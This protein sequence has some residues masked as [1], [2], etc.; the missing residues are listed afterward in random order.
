MVYLYKHIECRIINV[1][2]ILLLL[3]IFVFATVDTHIFVYPSLS[4]SLISELLILLLTTLALLCCIIKKKSFIH[5]KVDW[6]ILAWIA[7]IIIHYA[8][9][10]P[11]EQYRTIYLVVSLLLIPTVTVLLRCHL[12]SRTQCENT[13]LYTAVIHV[14]FV[15]AQWIGLIE[16]GNIYFVLTGSNENPTVTALYLVGCVP[17]IVVRLYSGGNKKIYYSFLFICIVTIA[18]LRCRT[19]YIGLSVELLIG[20]VVYF[21]N[22]NICIP[23]SY[24]LPFVLVMALTITMAGIKLY[25]MKRDSADGRILIWNI[26]AKMIMEK[27]QG[28]G[29]GLFEKHYN[30]RQAAYFAKGNGTKKEKQLADHVAMP[31]NDFLEHGVEGGVVGMVFLVVFYAIV[32]FN[33][34]REHDV[35]C[36]S[37]L[38]AFA[39]MSWTNF[40]YS[41]IQPWLLLMLLASFIISDNPI[42][43][44]VTLIPQNIPIII[45]AGLLSLCTPILIRM[46]KGQMKLFEYKERIMKSE[47]VSDDEF[48]SIQKNIGTSEA[49][50]ILRA[51]NNLIRK[52]Y[53]ESAI[54]ISESHN[55]T[56]SPQTMEMIYQVYKFSGYEERGIRYVETL[57][58]MVPALLYPKLLLLQYH[59]R[60][61]N[62]GKAIA[63][64]KEIVDCHGKIDNEKSKRIRSIA[65]NYIISHHQ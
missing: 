36:L 46:T 58:N 22:R 32:I 63:Y 26:S 7:Y 14:L 31:Y 43:E 12:I 62:I 56:S 42:K 61:G 49:Y 40:I 55:Y 64:A 51:Y 53:S 10:Y 47:S 25:E 54:D 39:L 23:R 29:Y 5:S 16:S 65:Y 52:R 50:W 60:K 4:R 9:V 57:S 6:F 44:G 15:F 21:K 38:V 2:T 8:C 33:T 34:K 35:V 18:A 28:Y 41:S 24:K 13:I 27:P 37:I 20:V 59:D 48:L 1:I 11:H 19:A 45:I 3:L 17:V 30:L